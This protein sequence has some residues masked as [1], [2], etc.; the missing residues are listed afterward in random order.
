[1]LG[2]IKIYSGKGKDPIYDRLY[3]R[4]KLRKAMDLPD[5]EGKERTTSRSYAVKYLV[6]FAPSRM[7]FGS[8]KVVDVA[9]IESTLIVK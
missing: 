2:K 3:I 7:L 6:V 1:M 9:G 4:E 5:D 8:A